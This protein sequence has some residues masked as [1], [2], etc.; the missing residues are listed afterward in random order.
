VSTD[1]IRHAPG[2]A[3]CVSF[4][5]HCH[6]VL[7]TPGYQLYRQGR[8]YHYRHAFRWQR[9]TATVYTAATPRRFHVALNRYPGVVIGIGF[10]IGRRAL[11]IVWGRPGRAIQLEPK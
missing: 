10:Q 3:E 6:G 9:P 7:G 2:S 4:G 1:P 11:S 8:P 5:M